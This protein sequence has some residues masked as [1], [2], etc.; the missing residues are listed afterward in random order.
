[1]P[2]VELRTTMPTVVIS[3]VNPSGSLETHDSAH[4]TTDK[5]SFT[6]T[7]A[8]VYFACKESTNCGTTS[9]E[10]TKSTVTITLAGIGKGTQATL[11]FTSN[12]VGDVYLF[13][14]SNKTATYTWTANG[15]CVRSVGSGGGSS[16]T[17]AK[18][19]TATSFTV[20]YDNATYTFAVPSITINNPY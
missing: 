1:M 8:T 6:A 18:E 11:T 2:H 13:D 5:N 19:L 16:K 10:Y 15:T 3:A 20:T 17:A 14:G 4:K 9:Y 12:E 7:S